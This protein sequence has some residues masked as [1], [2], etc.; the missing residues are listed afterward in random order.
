MKRSAKRFAWWLMGFGYQVM[1]VHER[2]GVRVYMLGARMHAA[3]EA[4]H[5]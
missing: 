4:D 3:L 5:D 1:D 2:S